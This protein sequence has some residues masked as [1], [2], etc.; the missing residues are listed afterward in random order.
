MTSKTNS[1]D[2]IIRLVLVG[3]GFVGKTSMVM[4]S[5][6]HKF[7]WSLK[8]FKIKFLEF[9]IRIFDLKKILFLSEKRVWRCPKYKA[10]EK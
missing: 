1:T 4:R 2:N 6:I 8:I 10:I 3:D 5:V 9:S 7:L